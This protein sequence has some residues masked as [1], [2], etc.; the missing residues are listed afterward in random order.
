MQTDRTRLHGVPPELNIPAERSFNMSL[1]FWRAC[2]PLP[3][4]G[5]GSFGHPGSGG[6][7][8]FADPDARIGFGYVTNHW[9]HRP[10]DL[11]AT[12]LAEAVR[13]CLG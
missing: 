8:A 4:P 2:A 3:M 10:D 7:T 9:N 12:N 13:A 1:G 11:R 6:S 5:P